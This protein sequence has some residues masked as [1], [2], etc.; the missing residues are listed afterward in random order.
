MLFFIP[1]FDARLI[2]SHDAKP[3]G[4]AVSRVLIIFVHRSLPT[5]CGL[6][7]RFASNKPSRPFFLKRK[8][9]LLTAVALR[10]RLFATEIEICHPRL[11]E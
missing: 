5:V 3:F 7:E 8:T 6:P 9:H 11:E 1:S 4:W 10:P 2:P